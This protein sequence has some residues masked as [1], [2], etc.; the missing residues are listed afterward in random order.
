MSI[1]KKK[2]SKIVFLAKTN[3]NRIELFISRGFH[4]ELF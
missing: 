3:L 1:I 4:H 2:H